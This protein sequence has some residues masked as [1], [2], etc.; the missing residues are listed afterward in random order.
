MRSS[1][2]FAFPFLFLVL[3]A[4]GVPERYREVYGVLEEAME[5]FERQLEGEE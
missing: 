4:V 3:G 5:R 1:S 2:L